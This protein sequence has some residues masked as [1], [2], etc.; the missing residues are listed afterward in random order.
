MNPLA[1][2]V[3][4]SGWLLELV[5]PRP[6]PRYGSPYEPSLLSHRAGTRTS[7]VPGGEPSGAQVASGIRSR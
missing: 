4:L 6:K 2:G 5:A 3:T 1:I 7:G